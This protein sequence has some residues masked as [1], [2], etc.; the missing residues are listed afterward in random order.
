MT[1]GDEELKQL[2]QV[3]EISTGEEWE[4][5]VKLL[6]RLMGEDPNREGLRRT[7]LRVKKSLQYLTSGYRQDP[8]RILNRSFTEVKH[9]EMVIVKDIDF[10]SLC[11]HHVLPFF[12]K[13]HIAYVPDK[14][15]IGLSKIPRLVDTFA[16]RLQVQERLTTQIAEA[17]NEHVKP[18][19]VACVVEASHLCMMM[20]GVQKQNARAVTSS[21]LGAFRTSEKTRAE[22]LTLIRSDL[23]S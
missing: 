13:C 5:A 16:H 21:M 1:S 17:I 22:F 7:P 3:L 6:L 8:A 9:D 2:R 23:A 18:L 11:E 14:K 20:R 12:G 4:A 15:I 10:F 19:G